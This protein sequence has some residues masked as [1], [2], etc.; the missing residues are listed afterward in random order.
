MA[1]TVPDSHGH[2]R[3]LTKAEFLKRHSNSTK[4]KGKT[5]DFPMSSTTPITFPISTT[6]PTAPHSP[7]PAQVAQ[8]QFGGTPLLDPIP[9]HPLSNLS[10]SEVQNDIVDSQPRSGSLRSRPSSP[11]QSMGSFTSFAPGESLIQSR[12]SLLA[13]NL[14]SRNKRINNIRSRIDDSGALYDEDVTIPAP[15]RPVKPPNFGG[16]PSREEQRQAA[17]QRYAWQRENQVPALSE[18]GHR[19][20]DRQI[21]IANTEMYNHFQAINDRRAALDREQREVQAQIA[22]VAEELSDEHLETQAP[23]SESIAT[24][25][26]RRQ[27]KLEGQRAGLAEQ[28][29]LLNGLGVEMN[30]DFIFAH[31]V[32]N[33]DDVPQLDDEAIR[34]LESMEEIPLD[35]IDAL[36]ES[37]ARSRSRSPSPPQTGGSSSRSRS[38]SRPRRPRTPSGTPPPSPIV[39]AS[40]APSLSLTLDSARTNDQARPPNPLSRTRAFLSRA[41]RGRTRRERSVGE[42]APVPA[43]AEAEAETRDLGEPLGTQEY[44][45]MVYMVETV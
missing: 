20:K 36:Y 6:T 22:S 37:R 42:E 18:A 45:C 4:S 29:A 12:V 25:H 1:H 38:A 23:P 40:A 19:I 14:G 8:I 2:L 41:V 31:T 24:K 13:D 27:K 21:L 17:S 34:M 9:I 30:P 26:A 3:M 43:A 5:A 7:R 10:L 16:F 32:I 15:E 28:A 35:S 33:D 39:T 44:E 11:A